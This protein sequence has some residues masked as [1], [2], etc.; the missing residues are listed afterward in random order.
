MLLFQAKM[1][2]ISAL[3]RC[4]QH[5]SLNKY[6]LKFLKLALKMLVLYLTIFS[7]FLI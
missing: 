6:S 4:T 3:D 5:E 2:L 7:E 1:R